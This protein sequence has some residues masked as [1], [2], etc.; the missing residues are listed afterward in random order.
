MSTPLIYHC[1]HHA[2]VHP[3]WSFFHRQTGP[4]Y[5]S[6]H[7]LLL[8]VSLSCSSSTPTRSTPQSTN[9]VTATVPSRPHKG[10]IHTRN[11]SIQGTNA[12]IATVLSR[13]QKEGINMRLRSTPATNVVTATVLSRLH[14]EEINTRSPSIQ[15]TNALTATIRSALQQDG[16]S[17]R[18][19]STV[20]IAAF[21]TEIF[22]PRAPWI[23]TMMP[24]ILDMNA[25]IATK[26]F[27]LQKPAHSM[28]MQSIDV[29][30]LFIHLLIS[31][32]ARCLPCTRKPQLSSLE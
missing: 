15:T 21:V 1:C 24:C 31:L 32:A 14:R 9:A 19:Q 4:P 20:S 10:E 7:A 26:S 28:K 12:V 13:L 30:A 6:L 3:L 23:S 17:T 29:P 18:G 5:G 11:R 22:P 25:V 16:T 2:C 27:H 8:A